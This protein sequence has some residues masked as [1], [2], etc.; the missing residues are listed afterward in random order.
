M[1]AGGLTMMALRL[2]AFWLSWVRYH[3]VKDFG[4]M[5]LSQRLLDALEA[6]GG[7]HASEQEKELR[8]NLHEDFSRFGVAEHEGPW[9]NGVSITGECSQGIK[10]RGNDAFKAGRN[11]IAVSHYSMAMDLHPSEASLYA[12]RAAAL[13]KWASG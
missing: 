7:E 3:V 8:K 6:W 1:G 12:N 5:L 10:E 13:L 11:L 4:A 2:L 9:G